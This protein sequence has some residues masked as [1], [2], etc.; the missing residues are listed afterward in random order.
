MVER[1]KLVR[2]YGTELL[3]EEATA[4][5]GMFR[6]LSYQQSIDASFAQLSGDD[7]SAAALMEQMNF[8]G[9]GNITPGDFR[10]MAN[11]ISSGSNSGSGGADV[12]DIFLPPF[13]RK[14]MEELLAA[15]DKES[16]LKTILL[17]E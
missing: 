17:C 14:A 10:G 6:M 16:E 7:S 13:V 8:S 9:E 15:Q 12:Q 5:Q 2:I 4:V 11:E 3:S 1:A